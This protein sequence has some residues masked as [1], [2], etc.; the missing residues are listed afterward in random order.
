M[1]GL[2]DGRGRRDGDVVE[3]GGPLPA[4]DGAV[5]E[6]LVEACLFDKDGE[7]FVELGLVEEFGCDPVCEV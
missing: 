1:V 4:E 6:D 3:P 5:G 2:E 7:R